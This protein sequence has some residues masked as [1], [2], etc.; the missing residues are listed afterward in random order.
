MSKLVDVSR[1]MDW[2]NPDD[3][4]LPVTKCVCGTEFVAWNFMISIY[5]DSPNKCPSCG[6]K[7]FFSNSIHIYEVI[8]E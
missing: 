5:E 1:Q 8:D 3:E 6:R 7:F 2:N 4:H